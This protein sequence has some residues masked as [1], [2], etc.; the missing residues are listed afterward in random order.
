V[1]V[2]HRYSNVDDMRARGIM[3]ALIVLT[4]LTIAVIIKN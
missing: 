2:S 4:A 3:I 1:G